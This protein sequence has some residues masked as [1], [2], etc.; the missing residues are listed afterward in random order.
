MNQHL[1]DDLLQDFVDGCVGEHTAVEVALHLDDCPLCAT[2][3]ATLEPLHGVF[4]R[5][6]E[7]EVPLDLADTILV[8][9]AE[10]PAR[11]NVEVLAGLA[12]LASA[13]ML[14]VVSGEPVRA[15]ARLAV[16][17]EASSSVGRTLTVVLPTSALALALCVA[18]LGV[19]LTA[20]TGS[21]LQLDGSR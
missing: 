13:L 9:A 20:L 1:D 18:L 15:L 7:P 19:L 12:L 8:A 21:R 5:S 11:T 2:R 17:L 16:W 14:A 3:A 10:P 6:S 4:A